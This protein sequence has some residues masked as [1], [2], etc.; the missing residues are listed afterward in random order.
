MTYKDILNKITAAAI[1]AG[2]PAVTIAGRNL[3]TGKP[4]SAV[5]AYIVSQ[6][7]TAP[8][9]AIKCGMLAGGL[10]YSQLGK[11][12]KEKLEKLLSTGAGAIPKE[13]QRAPFYGLLKESPSAFISALIIYEDSPANS[14]FEG[15]NAIL[16]QVANFAGVSNADGDAPEDGGEGS[17]MDDV[18][19]GVET[20]NKWINVINGIV[21]TWNSIKGWFGSGKSKNEKLSKPAAWIKFDTY[22]KGGANYQKPVIFENTNV[23]YLETEIVPTVMIKDGAQSYFPDYGSLCAA[24]VLV[25]NQAAERAGASASWPE[26]WALLKRVYDAAYQ[27]ELRK[28]AAKPVNPDAGQGSNIGKPQTGAFLWVGG[29]NDMKNTGFAV[30]GEHGLQA[31]DKVLINVLNGDKSYNGVHAVLYNGADDGSYKNT[32]FTCDITCKTR[33]NGQASGSFQKWVDT[34]N[35]NGEIVPP[36]PLPNSLTAGISGSWVYIGILLVALAAYFNYKG[37][38][39]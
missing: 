19:S 34:V 32:M 24:F 5:R 11:N 18:N 16:N 21:T 39:K 17:T 14:N 7:K 3:N 2:V 10:I 12:A 8:L 33:T 22:R 23:S 25:G 1:S 15:K 6:G 28:L 38:K 36:P 31:G 4:R 29:Q 37:G 27:L 13:F 9:D 30:A 20:A 35:E 26:F